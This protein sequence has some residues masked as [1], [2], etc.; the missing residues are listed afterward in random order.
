MRARH[1]GQACHCW[2][3]RRTGHESELLIYLERPRDGRYACWIPP[4]AGIG[5]AASEGHNQ[6]RNG[7]YCLDR[8]LASLEGQSVS[9]SRTKF[10]AAATEEQY[11]SS[12]MADALVTDS[13]QRSFLDTRGELTRCLFG[14]RWDNARAVL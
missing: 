10:D 11:E 6:K 2:K 1:R 5:A 9:K 3:I 12:P 7:E 14:E 4:S 13:D 8:H